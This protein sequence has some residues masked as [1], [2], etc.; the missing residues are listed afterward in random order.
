[1]KTELKKGKSAIYTGI[2]KYG[3][4]KFKLEILEYCSPAKCIKL[5]Q[6]YI[7]LLKPEYN[8]LKIAGSLLG[9]KHS[10]ET[11]ANMRKR[12]LSEEHKAKI[13]ASITGKNHPLFNTNRPEVTRAKISASMIGIQKTEQHKA[14]ISAALMGNSNRNKHAQKIE[15]TD[16]EL[17]TKTIYPYINAAARALNCAESSIRLYFR[18]NQQKP[19]KKRY[20]FTKIDS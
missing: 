15:V 13:L 4:E 14:K 7:N 17:N 10:E 16:L 12:K 19:Y 6:K 9:F 1:M 20:V 2:L 5:E 18:N 11:L 8:I 3:I